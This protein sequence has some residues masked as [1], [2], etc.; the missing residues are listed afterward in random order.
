MYHCNTFLSSPCF[1]L[2]PC[3]SPCS[4]PSLSFS[5]SIFPCVGI[6]RLGYASTW[7]IGTPLYAGKWALI[8]FGIRT[9]FQTRTLQNCKAMSCFLNLQFVCFIR[10]AWGVSS[11]LS[12]GLMKEPVGVF[13]ESSLMSEG[14]SR[15]A[16]PMFFSAV[17]PAL[18]LRWWHLGFSDS[19]NF[20]VY[21]KIFV[22]SQTCCCEGRSDDIPTPYTSGLMF[23]SVFLSFSFELPSV[24]SAMQSGI[25]WISAQLLIKHSIS[26]LMIYG[27]FFITLGTYFHLPQHFPSN[28]QLIMLPPSFFVPSHTILAFYSSPYIFFSKRKS[29]NSLGVSSLTS[30]TLH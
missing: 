1:L 14:L 11:F 28:A 21:S 18:L 12:D 24:F 5:F 16:A 23:K 20:G 2:F 6:L 10:S 29:N 8:K 4:P 3:P 13:E 25:F 22:V 17:T 15:F 26:F 9:S 19:S 30:S 7:E 27:V